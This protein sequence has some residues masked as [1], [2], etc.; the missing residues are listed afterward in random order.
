MTII[1]NEPILCDPYQNGEYIE[2][3]SLEE[4]LSEPILNTSI[5]NVSVDNYI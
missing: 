5:K 1:I 4:C 3:T 2:V